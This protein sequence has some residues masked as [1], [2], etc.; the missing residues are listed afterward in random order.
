MNIGKRERLPYNTPYE[1]SEIRSQ[2]SEGRGRARRLPVQGMASGNACPTKF[3]Y[4]SLL[5]IN[6]QQITAAALATGG[7]RA[8]AGHGIG[9]SGSRMAPAV[10]TGVGAAGG[11]VALGRIVIVVAGATA[12][13]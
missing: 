8:V 11:S 12:A 10:L 7:V 1:R 2:R 9:R 5:T 3:R 6:G 4:R 13:R